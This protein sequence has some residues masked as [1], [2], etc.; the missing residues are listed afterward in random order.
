MLRSAPRAVRVIVQ[1]LLVA[2]VVF[3]ALAY[4]PPIGAVTAATLQHSVARESGGQSGNGG[5]CKRQREDV[6]NCT[7][8]SA[9]GSSGTSYQLTRRGRR[10]WDAAAIGISSSP[11]L[12]R[13]LSGCAI[14]RDQVRL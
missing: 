6:W 9:D 11:D 2:I 12:P 5:T 14:L 3:A 13:S 8:I 10:C 7:V 4:L 1:L